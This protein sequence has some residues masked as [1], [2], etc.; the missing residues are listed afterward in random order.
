MTL[1]DACLYLNIN[2]DDD[3]ELYQLDKNYNIRL[4][5]YEP[6]RFDKE[7]PEYREAKRMRE[8]IEEAYDRLLAEYA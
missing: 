8:N 2:P 7:T 3:I 1:D 4:S 5:M 6:N